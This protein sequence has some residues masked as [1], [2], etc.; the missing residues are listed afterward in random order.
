MVRQPPAKSQVEAWVHDGII[1]RSQ[2]E[3]L[4]ADSEARPVPWGP[5]D[6][7]DYAWSA[8]TLAIVFLLP[9]PFMMRSESALNPGETAT[10]LTL[11]LC[12]AVALLCAGAVL[13]RLLGPRSECLFVASAAMVLAVPWYLDVPPWATALAF[14]PP[15][16]SLAVSLRP[17]TRLAL[18]AIGVAAAFMFLRAV[19]PAS[20]NLEAGVALAYGLGTWAV[21]SPGAARDALALLGMVLGAA[22]AAVALVSLAM[23]PTLGRFGLFVAAGA[24]F[25]LFL[26]LWRW[27]MARTLRLHPLPLDRVPQV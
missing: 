20:T 7:A 5:S 24:V 1:T 13:R 9:L 18:L 22:V 16:A 21:L 14:L 19:V 8:L 11:M 12:A 2:G 26:A 10:L 4:L 23:A 3:A 17:E 27:P 6:A 25:V 15:A